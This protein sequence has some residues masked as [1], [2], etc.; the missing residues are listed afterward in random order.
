M[1]AVMYVHLCGECACVWRPEID[2]KCLPLSLSI[3]CFDTESTTEPEALYLT[4][5]ASRQAP[6]SPL[7]LLPCHFD[8]ACTLAQQLFLTGDL[9][10]C[11]HTSVAKHFTDSHLCSTS[12]FY[13]TYIYIYKLLHECT[14][15]SI[16]GYGQFP[17]VI[18]TDAPAR[19][20]AVLTFVVAHH[21]ISGGFIFFH[22]RLTRPH[23]A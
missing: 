11:L 8:Y 19:A 6:E 18:G 3:L 20:N 22:S 4:T 23:S 1:R 12:T 17:A 2:V 14:C 5:L 21:G 10:S 13:N 15:C 16:A 9:N 7:S